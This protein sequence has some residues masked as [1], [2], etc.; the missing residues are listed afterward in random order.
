MT[1]PIPQPPA[2]P[3]IGNVAQMDRDVPLNS[4]HLLAATYGDI[5]KLNFLGNYLVILCSYE[6]VSEVSD[7]KRFKKSVSPVLREVGN[8]V[9]DG[10]FTAHGSEESWGIA[11]QH[12]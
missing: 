11:R 12:F 4:F 9:G 7:E 6:L 2:I 10:L 3:F 8:L 1:T 5:F